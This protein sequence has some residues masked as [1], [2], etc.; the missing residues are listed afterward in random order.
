V[1][2]A[3]LAAIHNIGIPTLCLI[4][5]AHQAMHFHELLQA[6][7]ALMFC[8]LLEPFTWVKLE[9]LARQSRSP[10]TFCSHRRQVPVTTRGLGAQGRQDTEVYSC[11][12]SMSRRVGG[13]GPALLGDCPA[14]DRGIA[15]QDSCTS[16]RPPS[17]DPLQATSK[18]R[19]RCWRN[20]GTSRTLA[21]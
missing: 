17:S 4:L 12:R 9:T 3:G 7:S 6:C 5:I 20:I 8:S 14:I 2:V 11:A 19:R 1:V 16:L 15:E 21:C 13:H 18:R 10:A